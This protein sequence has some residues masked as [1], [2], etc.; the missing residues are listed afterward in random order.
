MTTA[1]PTTPDGL[2]LG[3]RGCR[4]RFCDGVFGIYH[5][6]RKK[7][8]QRSGTA[9]GHVGNERQGPTHLRPKPAFLRRGDGRGKADSRALL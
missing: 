7:S 5:G 1:W 9:V 2:W 6:T 3:A 8:R 4:P